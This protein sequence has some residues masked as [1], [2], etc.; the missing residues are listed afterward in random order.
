MAHQSAADL[1]EVVPIFGSS[2]DEYRRFL[3]FTLLKVRVDDGSVLILGW[4]FILLFVELSGLIGT[5]SVVQPK[6]DISI[7]RGLIILGIASPLM[8]HSIIFIFAQL[9]V[10]SPK[11]HPWYQRWSFS[12][13]SFLM[14]PK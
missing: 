7:F 2:T 13:R 3:A 4:V 9:R 11:E 5:F 1:P 8:H 12:S 14:T 10:L 6:E